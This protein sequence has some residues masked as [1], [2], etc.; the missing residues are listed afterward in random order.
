MNISDDMI[1]W[2]KEHY[3]PEVYATNFDGSIITKYEFILQGCFDYPL[4][5]YPSVL[6]K[7]KKLGVK[8]DKSFMWLTLSPDKFQRNM[9]N[10]PQ[11]LKALGDW[12]ENWFKH[13]PSMYNGYKYVV[14]NGSSGDHLHVHAIIDFKNSHKHAEK[15]KRSWNRCFPNHQ[16]LTS[17]NQLTQAYKN[18]TKKGEYCYANFSDPLILQDKLDYLEDEKKGCHQNLSD[19]GVRGSG[20]VL[21][22]IIF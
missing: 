19:T 21:S 16:L 22:D 15:L 14:E 2:M 1:D 12:C 7:Y 4:S 3:G 11:N 5:V 13:N 8:K 18:G 6:N 9:D 17:V 20:G 10:N